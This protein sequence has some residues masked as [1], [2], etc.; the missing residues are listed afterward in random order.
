MRAQIRGGAV[1]V[2]TSF[3]V[4]EHLY[5]PEEYLRVAKECLKESG[6]FL[7][8]YDSGHAV[9]DKNRWKDMARWGLARL[10]WER[11][12]ETFVEERAFREMVER[13]GFDI[14]DEKFF[15]LYHLK[16]LGKYIRDQHPAEVE[17]YM[18]LWLDFEL[19]LNELDIDYVDSLAP[20]I[21]SRNFILVHKR[22]ADLDGR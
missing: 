17:A 2:V 7:I 15:Q 8:N 3:S 16:G 12:Y 1:D 13:V 5:R 21:G 22:A 4:F 20:V 6:W 9:Y 14:L 19:K 10:G 11:W 18:S